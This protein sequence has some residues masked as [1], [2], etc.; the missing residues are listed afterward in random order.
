[1]SFARADSTNRV[2]TYPAG[3]RDRIQELYTCAF[4]PSR[5][6][7]SV[8]G[9]YPDIVAAATTGRMDRNQVRRRSSQAEPL[10]HIGPKN[11]RA[12]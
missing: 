12:A 10:T 5:L 6:I 2:L 7:S 3:A 1:M 11:G 9:S 4:V 8:T